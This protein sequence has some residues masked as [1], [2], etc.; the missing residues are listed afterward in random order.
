MICR[1]C[2]EEILGDGTEHA[3]WEDIHEDCE[4]EEQADEIE[5]L[6]ARLQAEEP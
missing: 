6:E 1:Y 5:A 2:D 4:A 3:D